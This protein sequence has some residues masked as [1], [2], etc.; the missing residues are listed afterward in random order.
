MQSFLVSFIYLGKTHYRICPLNLNFLSPNTLHYVYMYHSQQ[1]GRCLLCFP[2]PNGFAGAAA[3]SSSVISNDDN[4][5][6]Q[7]GR[8]SRAAGGT[9]N[10]EGPGA[11]TETVAAKPAA[12]ASLPSDSMRVDEPDISLHQGSGI[13]EKEQV[14]AEKEPEDDIQLHGSSRQHI[15]IDD[16]SGKSPYGAAEEDRS[17]TPPTADEPVDDSVRQTNVVGRKRKSDSPQLK[18]QAD[19]DNDRG[20]KRCS[21]RSRSP[22]PPSA[23]N[24]RTQSPT[25]RQKKQS[26]SNKGVDVE[27]SIRATIK[28]LST[29]NRKAAPQIRCLKRLLSQIRRGKEEEVVSRIVKLRGV[30]CLLALMR[31]SESCCEVKH[32]ICEIYLFVF[33]YKE[34]KKKTIELKVHEVIKDTLS[35]HPTEISLVTVLIGA[36]RYATDNNAAIDREIIYDGCLDLVV[37]TAMNHRSSPRIQLNTMLFLQGETQFVHNFLF[38]LLQSYLSMNR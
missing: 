30:E 28:E 31:K 38:S 8:S 13:A 37:N 23:A 33:Y 15:E 3:A 34:G 36:L 5:S 20:I 14:P 22:K 9:I 10:T 1:N 12:A 29:E 25:K 26:A 35:R 17:T 11:A 21:L 2:L 32:L 6:D 16:S 7:G 19:D 27:A 18:S 24:K 4:G